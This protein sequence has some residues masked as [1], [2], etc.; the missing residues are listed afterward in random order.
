[1]PMEW[2]EG[3]GDEKAA[4]HD[5]T[6]GFGLLEQ[7]DWAGKGGRAMRKEQKSFAQKGREADN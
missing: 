3:L 2:M 4:K 6:H 5:N 1:M 7:S